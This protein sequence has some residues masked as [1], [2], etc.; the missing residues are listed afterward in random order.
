ML[1]QGQYQPMSIERQVITFHAATKGYLDKISL[2]VFCFVFLGCFWK[3]KTRRKKDPLHMSTLMWPM[4][5]PHMSRAWAWGAHM[6]ATA[7]RV[8]KC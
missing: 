5:N 2:F 8:L 3:K 1:K 6:H 4:E 7:V